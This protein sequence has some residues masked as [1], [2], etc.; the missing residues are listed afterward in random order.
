MNVYLDNSATSYP[1]PVEVE[2]ALISTLRSHPG[3]A[4]RSASAGVHE[5]ERLIYDTRL[6][7]AQ[8]FGFKWIDHVIFTKNIT[9][10]IN[11]FLQGY[12]NREDKVLYS[13][14]EHNAVAR[15]LAYLRASRGVETH[16]IPCDAFGQ[17]NL[18]ELE[19]ELAKNPKLLIV[20]HASNVTGDI[21][22]L[23]AIGS[24]AKQYN[25]TFFVDA[26]QS[27]GVIDIDMQA[28][29]IDVLGFTGHKSLLGPQGIGGLLIKPQIAKV[30][31][32]FCYG[33][34]GSLSEHIEQPEL[35]PDK[36]ESGTV[37]TLGILGLKASMAFLESIDRVK[38]LENERK[39]I[40]KLQDYLLQRGDVFVI[41]NPD[42]NARTPVISFFTHTKDISEIAYKLSK[43]YGIVSRVGLHC[44]P[45]AHE[46]Y[47][48]LPYGTIRLST[49]IYSTEAEIDYVI[50][51]LDSLL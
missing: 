2:E 12:L 44:A 15:P 7:I 10:S 16:K 19:K 29:N 50:E 34:T 9:E 8:F 14:I 17:M 27:G 33:G 35:M 42:V 5:L 45:L 32:P 30:T 1:K 22:N 25:V 6:K 46:T 43:D 28:L 39:L 20:N 3:N 31:R 24:L 49:S 18:V 21:Q 48:S 11:L 47:H 37:N 41:G 4:G 40:K 23:E 38:R 26:A 51:S 36:F 13:G